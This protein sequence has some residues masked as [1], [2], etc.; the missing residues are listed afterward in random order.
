MGD[1]KKAA[2]IKW[3]MAKLEVE[4]VGA[5]N[6]MHEREAELLRRL[7]GRGACGLPAGAAGRGPALL[8]GDVLRA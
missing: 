4:A 3:E 2:R 6:M 1:G 8:G 5:I 7:G